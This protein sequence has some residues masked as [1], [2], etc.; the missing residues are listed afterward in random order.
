MSFCVLQ[1][2]SH[3]SLEP[4]GTGECL[5]VNMSLHTVHY[6]DTYCSRLQLG[7]Y[8]LFYQNRVQQSGPRSK[9]HINFLYRVTDFQ[10][11]YSMVNDFVEDNIF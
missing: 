6:I 1:I 9:N 10:C 3:T 11:C 5:C 4:A 2:Q 8:E 7:D